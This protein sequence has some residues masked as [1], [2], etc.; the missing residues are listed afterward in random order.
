MK[1]KIKNLKKN[2][3]KKVEKKS[4][5][6]VWMTIACVFLGVTFVS[7]A[8]VLGVY[9]TGGFEEKYVPP[10]E[11]T[12]GHDQEDYLEVEQD[13]ELMLT[14]E[15]PEVTEKKVTLSFASGNPVKR[16]GKISNKIIQVPEIV[17]IGEPFTVH[18][19]KERLTDEEGN[20]ILENGQPVDWIVGG[21][22]T[23]FATSEAPSTINTKINIAVDVPVYDT[24]TVIINSNNEETTQIVTNESF[25]VKT[26]FIPAKSE[27]IYGDNFRTDLEESQMRKKLSYYEAVN[28]DKVYA[29]YDDIHTIHFV[30]G[31]EQVSEDIGVQ[32]NSYTFINAKTQLAQEALLA[33]VT[34]PETYH[35]SMLEALVGASVSKTTN[36][37][38]SIG[39]ASI[40]NFIVAKS[41]IEMNVG[42][43]RLSL[44]EYPYQSSID[45]LGV[46]IYSTNGILLDRLLPN[47]AI[48]FE[49]NGDDAVNGKNSVLDIN[50]TEGSVKIGEK[51]Y[52]KPYSKDTNPRFAYW[53]IKARKVCDVKMNIVLLVD[54][55]TSIFATGGQDLVYQTTLSV[56][57]HEELP[58]SWNDDSELEVMLDYDKSGNIE[59]YALNLDELK[60]IPEQ[61]IY[62]DYVFFASFGSGALE[63]YIE[64]ANRI[65]GENGYDIEKSG[66]Y[67]TNSGN[68]ELFAIDGSVLNLYDSGTFSLY[69]ATIITE[70]GQPKENEDGLYLIAE[71]A[72]GFKRIVC[73]KSL[74]TDSVNKGE[75]VTTNFPASQTGEVSIPQG[76]DYTFS[77][78]FTISKEAVAVFRDEYQQGF[79][80]PRIKDT[81]GNDITSYF[82]YDSGTFSV[83][84]ETGEGRLE[85]VLTVKTAVDIEEENGIYFSAVAL[86]YNDHDG[87]NIT[88]ETPLITQGEG[89]QIICIYKPLTSKVNIIPR[90][91]EDEEAYKQRLEYYKHPIKVNQTLTTEGVFNTTITMSNGEEGQEVMFDSITKFLLELGGDD[92]LSRIAVYD[93]KG[94]TAYIHHD[95]KFVVKEGDASV[96]SIA[97]N[98]QSFTFKDTKSQDIN[99]KLA[100]QSLDGRKLATHDA[101][102]GSE[103]ILD[104]TINSTG[105][106]L[107][108]YD[109]NMFTYVN[110]MSPKTEEIASASVNKYGAK[111]NETQFIILKNLMNFYVSANGT[112]EAY[113]N[114]SYKLN[115]QYILEGA[116]SNEYLIDLYGENGMLTLY[117]DDT[118]EISFNG[119]YSVSNIR[120]TLISTPVYKIRLN[121]NFAIEQTLHFIVSDPIGAV[122]TSLSLNLLAN[123][124]VSNSDYPEAGQKIYAG[125]NGYFNLNNKVTNKNEGV[126]E[127]SFES[128]YDTQLYYIVYNDQ[129][130][131]YELTT[132]AVIAGDVYIGT[133]NQGQILFRDFW[134]VESKTYR[135]FFQPEGDNI[136]ALNK[137]ITFEV[138]RDL[139]VLDGQKPVFYVLGA[140]YEDI[141]NFAIVRRITDPT[142]VPSVAIT[143]E[144]DNYLVYTE[145]GVSK[146]SESEFFFNYNQKLLA[147]KLY[148]KLGNSNVLK[149]VDVRIELFNG[150]GD[151]YYDLATRLT[152]VTTNEV[153]SNVAKVQYVGDV[154]YIMLDMTHTVWAYTDLNTFGI[155]PIQK[156]Y[157]SNSLE[158]IYK[159]TGVTEYQLSFKEHQQLLYG[160]GNK[161]V[162]M[163]LKFYTDISYTTEL[164]IMHVPVILS[165]IGY[166][167]VVYNS[168]N[169]E[170]GHE[171]E[172][173]LT[174]P[175]VLMQRVT[176]NIKDNEI[177]N[178]IE[179]GKLTQ[180]LREIDYTDEVT[181]GGLYTVAN[182]LET[183]DVYSLTQNYN[184]VIANKIITDSAEGTAGYLTLNHLDNSLNDVFIA[185]TYILDNNKG[186]QQSFYY[187]LKVLPDVIVE[188][189]LYAYN[190][191]SEYITGLTTENGT[192]DF[193]SIFPNTTLHEGYKRFNVSKNISIAENVNTL[194]VV[195]NSPVVLKITYNGTEK[196]VTL[197]NTDDIILTGDEGL[198]DGALSTQQKLNVM[199]VS[200][201]ADIFYNNEKVFSK[202]TYVNEVVSVQIGDKEPYTSE[203]QWNDVLA[204]SFSQDYRY[205]TYR[206]VTE[207]KMV[208]T[209]KHTYVSGTDSLG[210]VGKEQFYTFIL[211]EETGNYTVRFTDGA[212]VTET[213]VYN[214]TIKN[215]VAAEGY[216]LVINLI[217]NEMAG[218]SL[219]QT[220]EYDKLDITVTSGKESLYV[221]EVVE[222]DDLEDTR[223]AE[224][225]AIDE[226]GYYYDK[227]TGA[228]KFKTKDYIDADKQVNFTI[229][230]EQGYLATL[231]INLKAN[232]SVVA[233]TK[234]LNGGS[235]NAF[236]NLFD[237][238]LEDELQ[239]LGEDYTITSTQIT[240]DSDY[241][242]WKA[243]NNSVIV[244]DLINN[245]SVT[246]V[247]T[248]TFTSSALAGEFDGKTFIFTQSYDL[249]ANVSPKTLEVNSNVI[250]AND[251]FI[252]DTASL[253][254]M[255][256]GDALANSVVELVATSTTAAYAGIE[257]Y[258]V[259]TNYVAEN[260]TVELELTVKIV[261]TK[262]DGT[263]VY[264]PYKMTYSFAVIPSAELTPN[265]P[266]PNNETNM[267]FEYVENGISYTNVLDFIKAKA[268]FGDNARV[269]VNEYNKTSGK[270]DL[271]AIPTKDTLK[272]TVTEINNALLKV[273]T[274]IVR[275]ND[276]LNLEEALNFTRGV[277]N[278]DSSIV[279]RVTYQQVSTLYK[280]KII[281]DSLTLELNPVTNYLFADTYN[282]ATV[283][284]EKIYVDKT[285]T[286]G[287]FDES[288][289]VYV[290]IN[291]NMTD[292]VNEY[293]MLFSDGTNYYSSRA[294]FFALADQGK[295]LY[296]DLGTSMA[297]KNYVGTFLTTD[298]E[299]LN[300]NITIGQPIKEKVNVSAATEGSSPD[301]EETPITAL[302]KDLVDYTNR[303]FVIDSE[304]VEDVLT[305]TP[306][307][308]T[309]NRV[310]MIYGQI[311]GEDI[312]VDY[313]RY[314]D[315]LIK[316]AAKGGTFTFSENTDK[317][318]KVDNLI[319]SEFDRKDGSNYKHSFTLTYYYMPS[320][321]IAVREAVTTN[322]NYIQVE[323]NQEYMSL[324]SLLGVIHPTTNR[325]VT[326]S[327]FMS[328]GDGLT[329][330]IITE[331]ADLGYA[332]EIITGTKGYMEAYGISN[333][334]IHADSGENNIYVYSSGIRNNSLCVY[335]YAMIPFGAQNTGDFVLGQ[336][337]YKAG[338]FTKTFYIVMKIVPDYVVT[339]GGSTDNAGEEE[340]GT[341]ISNLD[342]IYRIADMTTPSSTDSTIYYKEFILAGEEGYLSIT[343]K[344]GTGEK[345]ELSGRD[346]NITITENQV[347]NSQSYNVTDNITNKIMYGGED[348]NYWD[349]TTPAGVCIYQFMNEMF[350]GDTD[351]T[352][353]VIPTQVKFTGV[354]QV[355]FG[356]QYYMM[357][358]V[359]AYNYKYR[360]YFLL[361]ATKQ[362]PTA[363][364]SIEIVENGYFDIGVKYEMLSITEEKLKDGTFSYNINSIEKSPSSV[365]INVP[366][367]NIE[368][369]ESW[370]FDQDYTKV[371]VAGTSSTT[372]TPEGET[373]VSGDP[374]IKENTA[375]AGY[376]A[377]ADKGVVFTTEDQKYLELSD[378]GHVSITKINFYTANEQEAVLKATQHVA[379]TA[380][381]TATES[382]GPAISD[383]SKSFA[384][385]QESYY[386]GLENSIRSPYKLLSEVEQPD[387]S[388]TQE[389][390]KGLW[391][392]GKL[393][394]TDLFGNT[395]IA[396]LTML[397][398]LKYEKGSIL[399][400]YDCPVNVTVR[401]EVQI[402]QID[403]KKVQRDGQEFEV[404]KQFDATVANGVALNDVEYINDTL[405]VLV[406]RNSTVTFEM[407]LD[408]AG[409]KPEDTKTSVTVQNTGASHPTTRY[410]SFSQYFGMNVKDGDKVVISNCSNQDT[411]FYYVE[412]TIT[413][414][415][416]EGG[417]VEEHV[418]IKNNN[419]NFATG[420]IEITF[421]IAKIRNDVIYI[422]DASLLSA[423]GYY[424]VTKYYILA[425][426]FDSTDSSASTFYYRAT[427]NYSVTG[428]VYKLE[429]QFTR[430]IGFA[431]EA[432]QN[433]DGSW[434]QA[435]LSQW[436]EKAFK[437]YEGYSP[438]GAITINSSAPIDPTTSTTWL[439]F[440]LSEEDDSTTL[441]MGKATITPDGTIQ[442]DKSFETDQYIKVII[443][444]AVSG[445]DRDIMK[446]SDATYLTLSVLNI[447]TVR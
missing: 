384:T 25:S 344:N 278:G 328:E 372:T 380:S 18:L 427:R 249:K 239:V 404:S 107:I 149:V 303:L 270:Y 412:N 125:A 435:N 96:I 63:E 118:T 177:Y 407:Y 425:T 382:E 393:Q 105:V 397:I 48:N 134:E 436:Y 119:N 300:W 324:V 164:A 100:I 187:L 230:I 421:T 376:I 129:N 136:F 116:L 154:E 433:A 387:G 374:Y 271:T 15:T 207:D 294:I 265:Y 291:D 45:Y 215:S 29:I 138:S 234:T 64:Q 262:L 321:D 93:Q 269:V 281:K 59:R 151:I 67:S 268:I 290:D 345:I 302:P 220:I 288:R 30:A 325:A 145:S 186:N 56:S 367:V 209:I 62:Q 330:K 364:N 182:K 420:A 316:D 320:L 101:T 251:K 169:V 157:Y 235:T 224:E 91:M 378:L 264:Q 55:G 211:N 104:F 174:N 225:I 20:E 193:E 195:V 305:V 61:N 213:Q 424:G 16:E 133:F 347:I 352:G 406:P 368:G 175:E 85:Y 146:S 245:K 366:L 296:F 139:Q 166:Y 247:Y 323:V 394:D 179:A 405:E 99:V 72:S 373:V 341:I 88:W 192:V 418:E 77:L 121:K 185:F 141:D 172:I 204:V 377:N 317:I 87:K 349:D 80:T 416:G 132:D 110:V 350:Y 50:S 410:I 275:V 400:Y 49:I 115:P 142:Q 231:T 386:Y 41:K 144:F 336:L 3:K 90:Q 188:E 282:T 385:T 318:A 312:L 218:S 301:T 200:G 308:K 375:G 190:G 161:Q 12:L 128:L 35:Q 361:Q 440:S 389:I 60:Y 259:S 313:N 246:F 227:S 69:F 206:P 396:E 109:T 198:F 423:T 31:D 117:S 261:Y 337:D 233:K 95:W 422:E 165:N 253:Y 137:V 27:Y 248:I 14:T 319:V 163:A 103:I 178:V 82:S 417:A 28:T 447:S 9:L 39:E 280:V 437:L 189:P 199:I 102:D 53:D 38:I 222:A 257:G 358:G 279:F 356:N 208:I 98:G 258:E 369:I 285:S 78:I 237:I 240:G 388:T 71:M 398:T 79:M 191:D 332:N 346:F 413:E 171:L 219:N 442:L 201:D 111:G 287:L 37:V 362:T 97:E 66:L 314:K 216:D 370:V 395:N 156:D 65:F 7:G 52:Y 183:L 21:L 74:Y 381:T 326:A 184:D 11:I 57:E 226:K 8:T 252:I 140:S 359:D 155:K 295:E 415:T 196:M 327:N 232:A 58:V 113:T 135:V 255:I 108:D 76:T 438:E 244:A 315:I 173:A 83:N 297:G 444:M 399:E 371:Y 256:E 408:R 159:V 10:V 254:N 202:L 89:A 365:D 430:E 363:Q 299:K 309:A 276:E 236:A 284:F 348:Q 434:P 443:K 242:D 342:Y 329:F 127:G 123:V 158:N 162:F 223:T 112:E 277:S 180:I 194:N 167:S 283:S 4:K 70:Y 221:K 379:A 170:E 431:I 250:V 409:L 131:R 391:N 331:S 152:S 205:M 360:L 197:T 84:G 351:T 42:P 338:K 40:G 92:S 289:M 147:S 311:D 383:Y 33:E 6:K 392:I 306:R 263:K 304:Y 429:R 5:W 414:T 23:I 44:N 114:V 24:E 22:S 439:S 428:Y 168:E 419:Q 357:E 217:K 334:K 17:T 153:E 148:V 333:F 293:Y 307:V 355:I 124:V 130:G 73:E 441:T 238:S 214:P 402:T 68:L 390:T 81:L 122:N 403:T 266:V 51:T 260:V 354:K 86:N 26:K 94:T 126:T 47:I 13:F 432:V 292:Y 36:E 160:L 243:D 274:T 273:G 241:V 272:V 176:D 411:Q 34:D 286:D 19:L 43:L 32:I 445:P 212:N 426:K 46:S 298:I 267:T 143:F 335:D 54:N 106:S 353:L 1:K 322:K 210:V 228:F 340:E 401:R 229:Y 120:Q 181:E 203:E 150:S 339:Y 2:N 446:T 75:I 310:Q 343:H